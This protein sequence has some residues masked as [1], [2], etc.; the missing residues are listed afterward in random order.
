MRYNLPDLDEERILNLKNE[1]DSR[2]TEIAD[3]LA[4]AKVVRITT[5]T[6]ADPDWFRRATTAKKLLGQSSQ[7]I[8]TEQARRRRI[9]RE[10]GGQTLADCFMTVAR[11]ELE[12]VDFQELLAMAVENHR[13]ARAAEDSQ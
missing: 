7:K 6:Y 4:E 12:H 8:Q 10:G 9:R 2:I 13:A 3:Q 11:E 1:V 5:G